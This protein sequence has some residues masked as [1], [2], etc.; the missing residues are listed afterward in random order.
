[1]QAVYSTLTPVQ[2][3]MLAV[4]ETFENGRPNT[5][6][7]T[8]YNPKTNELSGG[9]LMAS[10][11]SG[12]LGRLLARYVSLGGSK[13]DPTLIKGIQE[14]D[15]YK[16]GPTRIALFQFQF[17]NAGN[18][19]LMRTAQDLFFADRFLAPAE[20]RA[21]KLGL[22]E[23]LGRL[24]LLDSQVHGS[25]KTVMATMSMEYETGGPL[26]E[27]DFVRRYLAARYK[28]LSENPNKELHVTVDRVACLQSLEKEGN[29]KLDLPVKLPKK[30]RDIRK[31]DLL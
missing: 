18:D 6:H 31:E 10:T 3:T 13:I 28:W 21:D 17:K 20:I 19:P 5:Y 7:Q 26:N 27:W 12:N 24:V 25:L 2:K 1:M 9:R 14:N 11:L 30:G 8:Y 16:L 22:R 29:W 4:V 15:P 23:P